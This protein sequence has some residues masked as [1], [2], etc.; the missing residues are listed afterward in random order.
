MRTCR[1]VDIFESSNP[2]DG[3]VRL[4]LGFFGALYVAIILFDG[5]EI[6]L[7]TWDV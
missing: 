3:T 5:S 2:S 4:L 6:Q 7:T 1:D